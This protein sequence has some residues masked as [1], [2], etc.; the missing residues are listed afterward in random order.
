MYLDYNNNEKHKC[1]EGLYKDV[2]C[3]SVFKSNELFK[4]YPNSLQLQ[5]FTDGFEVCSALKPK[6]NLYG[7]VAIYFSILNLPHELAFNQNNIHLVAICNANDLKTEQTD[8]NTVWDFLVKNIR[9]L[10]TEGINIGDHNI[11]SK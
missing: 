1:Q 8:F 4:K 3:G 5:I 6:T 9:K 2:C 7:Q 10:E 11:K